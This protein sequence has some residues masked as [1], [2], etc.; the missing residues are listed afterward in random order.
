MFQV[1]IHVSRETLLG[2][3]IPEMVDMIDYYTEVNKN[4]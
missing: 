1:L 2:M 4:G 3:S